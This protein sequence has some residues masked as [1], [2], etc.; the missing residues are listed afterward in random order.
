MENQA[1]LTCLCLLFTQVPLG[2]ARRGRVASGF[3]KVK[4]IDCFAAVSVPAIDFTIQLLGWKSYIYITANHYS[5]GT[6]SRAKG[7]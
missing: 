1:L 2:C 7:D 5:P 6:L 4:V 3:R